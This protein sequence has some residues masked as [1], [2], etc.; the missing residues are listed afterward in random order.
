MIRTHCLVGCALQRLRLQSH[1]KG[2]RRAFGYQG[3]ST[4]RVTAA[5]G[6]LNAV[7]S[8]EWLLEKPDSQVKNMR[9]CDRRYHEL[10]QYSLLRFAASAA[11]TEHRRAGG[12]AR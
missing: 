4:G 3:P 7:L 5:S 10:M 2:Q 6:A 1:S 11:D 8:R 9:I 12:R